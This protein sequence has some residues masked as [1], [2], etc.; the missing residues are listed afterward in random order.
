[1][2]SWGGIVGGIA[3]KR[4]EQRLCKFRMPLQGPQDI[5]AHDIARAF[6]DGVDRRF[7]IQ[8]RHGAVFDIAIAAPYLHAFGHRLDSALAYPEFRSRRTDTAISQIPRI[9]GRI[10]KASQ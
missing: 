4:R 2:L 5:Q 10:K 7:S 3:L 1:M 8:P 6:P 9:V